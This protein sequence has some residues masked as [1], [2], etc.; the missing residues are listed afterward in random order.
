MLHDSQMRAFTVLLTNESGAFIVNVPSMATVKIKP[1]GDDVLVLL[2][3]DEDVCLVVDLSNTSP[4][5]YKTKS[6]N[7][8]LV[9][10]DVDKI[11]HNSSY[12]KLV[13]NCSSSQRPPLHHFS[14]C[15][16]FNIVDALKIIKSRRRSKS[17]L[18][19]IDFDMI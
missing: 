15:S 13:C 12:M 4:Y 11:P 18:T 14:S 1:S 9:F 7:P 17:D 16:G 5:P 8:V 2:D 3:S 6:S 19:A 10:V